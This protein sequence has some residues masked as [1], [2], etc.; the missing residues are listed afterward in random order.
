MFA[1]R[2]GSSTDCSTWLPET[3]PPISY[4]VLL[5]HRF[6][7][8]NTSPPRT[9]A[10]RPRTSEW[11]RYLPS[12]PH[13]RWTAAPLAQAEESRAVPARA[14]DLSGHAGEAAIDRALVLKTI[15]QHRDHVLRSPPLLADHSAGAKI[16]R[17][18]RQLR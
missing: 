5:R 3:S 7:S 14:G 11:L 12:L 4:R 6:Q 18:P 13:L 9:C 1:N 17:C 10:C 2:I 16:G 8:C 15:D